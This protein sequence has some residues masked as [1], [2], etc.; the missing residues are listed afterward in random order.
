MF[1]SKILSSIPVTVTVCAVFQ[2]AALKTSEAI[3]T[4]PSLV[5]LELMGMVT[6]AV[7]S[8]LSRTV[9]FTLPPASVVVVPE[10]ADTVIPAVSS[11]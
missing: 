8:E 6:S 2:L 5:S 9:K 7:G 10:G 11:S 4:V 3:L 1:P